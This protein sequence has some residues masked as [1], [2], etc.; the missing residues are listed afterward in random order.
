ME[1]ADQLPSSI[2]A[3]PQLTGSFT[4]KSHQKM[5]SYLIESGQKLASVAGARNSQRT[6]T[7]F[8]QRKLYRPRKGHEI[9]KVPHG[10]EYVFFP[11]RST[12]LNLLLMRLLRNAWMSDA[13]AYDWSSGRL[14]SRGFGDSL[15]SRRLGV[16][17]L[18]NSA[19][20]KN[21]HARRRHARGE[22]APSPLACLPRA[23][24]FSFSPTTS[25]CLLGR[26]LWWWRRW[27]GC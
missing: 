26:L 18:G 1:F 23:R 13:S 21:K 6:Q 22:G 5:L 12:V 9:S 7:Y 17:A 19:T 15:R 4:F 8:P 24:P 16:V 25:K 3:E 2:E 20:R 14:S 10:G 27:V 11:P